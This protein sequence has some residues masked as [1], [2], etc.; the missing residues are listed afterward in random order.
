MKAEGFV[1]AHCDLMQWSPPIENHNSGSAMFKLPGFGFGSVWDSLNSQGLCAWCSLRDTPPTLAIEGIH[2]ECTNTTLAQ[3][4]Q[5]AKDACMRTY[6]HA[7]LSLVTINAAMSAS[8]IDI[9]T[10]S[11]DAQ[12]GAEQ[13]RTRRRD[14]Q[15]TLV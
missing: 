11:G 5:H 8:I 15:P 14:Q 2:K 1:L 10:K 7:P 12:P 4:G 9:S 13:Q 3:T 6:M